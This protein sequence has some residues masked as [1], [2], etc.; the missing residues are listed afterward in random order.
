MKNHEF[1][2]YEIS[3]YLRDFDRTLLYATMNQDV[4]LYKNFKQ[5]MINDGRIQYAIRDYYL[6]MISVYE[7]LLISKFLTALYDNYFDY[8]LEASINSINIP[9]GIFV[10]SN[11]RSKFSNKQIIK[12]IRNA[13]NHNDNTEFDL[14]KFIRVNEGDKDN[15]KVEILLRNTKPIP[16]HIVLDIKDLITISYEIKN[17]STVIIGSKRSKRPVSLNSTNADK[18][19]NN[20]FLRKFF[21]RKKLTDA[22][23]EAIVSCVKENNKTKNYEQFFLENGMEYRDIPYDIAQKIRIEEDLKY[24]ESL[25]KNGDDVISH[26]L[27]KVMPFSWSKDRVLT[28]NLILANWYMRKDGSTILD[29]ARDARRVYQNKTFD[30]KSPLDLYCRSFGIDNRIIYDS[31][32]LYN[33]LSITDAIYYGYLFDT[34]ITDSK[35]NIND[36]KSV[37]REKIRDSFVHMRWYKGIHECFKLFD[38]D[39]GI[40]NEYNPNSPGF[41]KYNIKYD[42][43]IKCAELYFQRIVEPKTNRDGYMDLPIHFKKNIFEDGTSILTSI[44]F[45]KKGVFYCCLLNDMCENTNLL[46]RDESQ[47]GRPANAEEIMCFISEL[48][49]LSEKEKKDFSDSIEAIKKDLLQ[50]NKNNGTKR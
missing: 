34:L 32:D 39:N 36:S 37:S 27:D 8:L 46:V 12:Y 21:A 4:S 11:D 5:H 25:G 3:T 22:Q 43:M 50:Y 26:L 9:D 40:D 13:F 20:M 31:E 30:E 16:F 2:K 48:D 33:I 7:M 15:I 1:T 23:K 38:W 35:I 18:V 24:W 41:W 14:V 42:D 45:I 28:M 19:L 47:I 6:E 44:S 10:N 17:H 29:L 49:N